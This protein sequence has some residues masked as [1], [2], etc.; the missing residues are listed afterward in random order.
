VGYAVTNSV[1]AA[2]GYRLFNVDYEHNAFVYDV[3]QQGWML[4]LV[5]V[6]GTN[7]LS[8]TH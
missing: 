8:A 5:W 6:F 7:R 2:I 3:K 1:V 4:G